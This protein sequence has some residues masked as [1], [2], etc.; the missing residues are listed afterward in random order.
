MTTIDTAMPR[1]MDEQLL[2]STITT[3]D[4][5]PQVNALSATLTMGWRAVLKL[6][7]S[8]TQL[9]DVT[10]FPILMTLLFTYIFGGALSGSVKAYVQELLPGMLVITVVMTSMYTAIAINN[11]IAKGIFDRFRSLSFWR[12]AAV[13]GALTGDLAR[14]TLAGLV[15]LIVGVI[16]GF[17][18]DAGV[19]GV[20]LGLALAM[21]FAFSLS[22]V[23]TT[24]GL[25][26][27]DGES[28][29][30]F[31]QMV[32]FPLT[33]MSNIFVDPATMPA[34]VEKFVSVNPVSLTVMAVRGAMHGTVTGADIAYVLLT[35]VTITAIF[36]PLTMY[37]YNNKNTR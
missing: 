27:D 35:C 10:M 21:L 1:A 23:W 12:P 37:L 17:R 30:L 18:P 34:L 6:K 16:L 33:F 29:Y 15:V 7:H 19:S 4:R 8:P 25:L 28:V 11:D 9:L 36:A 5:P 31:S 22:W 3:D 2:A 26:I 20:I 13:I 24:L 32:T 14:Y